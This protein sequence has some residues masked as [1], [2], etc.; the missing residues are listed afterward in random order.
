MMI[1]PGWRI[2]VVVIG[3]ARKIIDGL[4]RVFGEPARSI[5]IG[6]HIVHTGIPVV[7]SC[8]EHKFDSIVECWIFFFCLLESVHKCFVMAE[9]IIAPLLVA[10]PNVF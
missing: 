3:R 2:I 9:E 5:F 7:Y 6:S 10:D 1:E 4:V 8:G